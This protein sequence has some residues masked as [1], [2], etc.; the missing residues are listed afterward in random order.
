MQELNH[1]GPGHN[2]I[3]QRDFHYHAPADRI[4]LDSDLAA[5]LNALGKALV[6][7][8]TPDFGVKQSSF[9]P[10]AKILYN[11]VKRFK[12]IINDYKPYVG[13]LSNIYNE[14]E[15]Q[16][17]SKKFFILENINITY[18]NARDTLLGKHQ[19]SCDIEVIREHADELIDAVEA[20]LYAD[21][22]NSMNNAGSHESIKV[23]L[24]IVMI[25]A[26]IRCKILEAPQDNAVA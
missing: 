17:S 19:G 7:P 21:V 1:Y 10:E 13:K 6:N 23:C 15:N 18:K 5:V 11:N 26:F 20:N 2:Q 14:Y 3:A 4:Q 12:A 16:G 22:A 8:E 9:A 24:Q 25:D